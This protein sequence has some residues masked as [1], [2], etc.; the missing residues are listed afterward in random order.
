M[1]YGSFRRG[2]SLMQIAAAVVGTAA[3]ASVIGRPA[4]DVLTNHNVRRDGSFWSCRHC[5]RTWPYPSPLPDDAGPCV[6]RKWRTEQ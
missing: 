1:A 5:G 4:G 6:P 2:L 3:A